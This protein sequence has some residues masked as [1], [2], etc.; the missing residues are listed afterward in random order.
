MRP[1]WSWPSRR[2]WQT[3]PAQIIICAAFGGR[4]DHMLANVL[5]LARPDLAGR[6]VMLVEGNQ[7]LRAL[8]GTGA[9][10]GLLELAGAPG[11]LL[12]LLPIGG[13]AEGITTEG[14]RY[15]LRDETL[16][17]GQARGV[18]NVFDAP[19]RA[20]CCGVGCSWPYIQ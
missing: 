9:A 18:S 17:L 12:T 10:P 11:D 13:D 5:L 16:F 15:P 8:R 7:V 4:V 2:P 19:Q 6:D 1:T 20:S 14:L 3:G